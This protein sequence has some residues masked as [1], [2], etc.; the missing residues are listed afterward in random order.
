MRWPVPSLLAVFAASA[1]GAQP[2]QPPQL[3]RAPF[4]KL[5]SPEVFKRYPASP[6]HDLKPAAPIVS[7]GQAHLFRTVIREQAKSG[8]D[9]AGHFTIVRIGCGSGMV[10]LAIADALTGRVF[11]SPKLKSVFIFRTADVERLN[12]RRDSRLLIAAG[13][14]NE[15][16]SRE[17]LSYY[18]WQHDKFRLIRFIP[19]AKLC[20]N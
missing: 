13:S 12:Y 8:P 3:C 15:D 20:K 5:L 18:L 4:E 6:V 11:F 16:E 2:A 7:N 14:P 9:F 17:G 1:L 19:S 10:C